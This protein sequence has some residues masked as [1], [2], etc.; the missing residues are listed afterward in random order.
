MCGIV[1]YITDRQ[2][3]I[4]RNNF[5]SLTDLL[6]HRG[7]DDRGTFEQHVNNVTIFLGHRRLSIIDTSEAGHQPM[8][9]HDERFVIV[10]NGEIYNYREVRSLLSNE[11]IKFYTGSDTE[12]ILNAYRH[13]GVNCLNRLNGMF[14]FAIWDAKEKSLFICRDRLGIK[15][16]YYTQTPNNLI[17]ASEIKVILNFPNISPEPD[18]RALHNPWRFNVAPNTG[19]SNINKLAPGHYLTYSNGKASI[20]RYWDITPTE[21]DPGEKQA[22]ERLKELLNDAIRMNMVADV[23]VGAFLSGGLDSSLICALASTHTQ[24]PLNTFTIRFTKEDNAYE[25]MPD[26]SNYARE[27]ANLLGCKHQ[28]IVIQPDIVDLLPKLVWHMDEPISDPAAINS[29]LISDAAREAGIIVL[30]SGMGGDEVFGGYRKHL[31]CLMAE[32]YQRYTPNLLRNYAERLFESLPVASS[33]RGFRNLRWIKR[34]LSF[35]SLSQVERFLAS[36]L[37]VPP[38]LYGELFSNTQRYPYDDAPGVIEHSRYLKNED[39]SYLTRMCLADSKLFLPEHNMTYSDK[40]TMAASVEVRPPLV[41]H[42]IVEY[43][44]SLPPRY[45]IRGQKQKYLLKKAA[46]GLLPHSIIDRPKGSFSS[47]IRSWIRG[48]LSEMVDDLLSPSELQSTGLLRPD[49]VRH[50]VAQDRKGTSD[51]ALLIWTLLTW[52]IWFRTFIQNKTI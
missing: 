40:S 30:L 5:D 23:P 6:A 27:V 32:Q 33:K 38:K 21:R 16:L 34:F 49:A 18:L 24:R 47:P 7:P 44:F 11:G 8:T 43:M 46:D 25:A 26:E 35:A 37:S 13:W 17:F 9:T 3:E 12:V 41:D 14:A 15:P 19:F 1:G 2:P 29:Y 42:H 36:D 4:S 52:Q 22:L 10:Y 20:T 31:A 45:R 50:L 51:H 48:P 39:L 28:E